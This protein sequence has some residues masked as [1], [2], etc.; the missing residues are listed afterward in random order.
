[1]SPVDIK[2]AEI[3]KAASSSGLSQKFRAVKLAVIFDVL[4]FKTNFLS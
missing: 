2:S 3:K 1:M 4:D